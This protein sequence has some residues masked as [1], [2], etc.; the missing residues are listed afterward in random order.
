MISSYIAAH[1]I[2]KAM[3]INCFDKNVLLTATI[4]FKTFA[5]ITTHC[6][7]MLILEKTI[8]IHQRT[9]ILK[10]LQGTGRITQRHKKL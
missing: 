4:D 6:F 7:G 3:D 1:F 5:K 2:E 8:L 10:N 9:R